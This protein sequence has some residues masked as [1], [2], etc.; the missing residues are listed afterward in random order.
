MLRLAGAVVGYD[1]EI[2]LVVCSAGSVA[3]SLGGS[4]V[5]AASNGPSQKTS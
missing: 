4:G 2:V 3:S 1:L 5:A